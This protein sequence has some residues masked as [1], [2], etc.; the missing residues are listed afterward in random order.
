MALSFFTCQV[1]SAR[2]GEEFRTL[3]HGCKKEID[4]MISIA[5]RDEPLVAALLA[6]D[7]EVD[8]KTTS[9]RVALRVARRKRM[10]AFTKDTMWAWPPGLG[11]YVIVLFLHLGFTISYVRRGYERCI[12]GSIVYWRRRAPAGARKKCPV[13][14]LPGVGTGLLQMD[15][16]LGLLE[17]QNEQDIL[18][19]SS[20]KKLLLGL[21]DAHCLS[22]LLL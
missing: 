10:R 11:I 16:L 14:V 1:T 12:A 3:A 5:A 9:Q 19:V 21:C 22:L 7:E 18:A 17:K 15:M 2:A 20:T 4:D 8:S 6:R 13:V